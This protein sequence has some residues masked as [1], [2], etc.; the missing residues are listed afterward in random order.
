MQARLK[1]FLIH[2]GIS[3]LIAVGVVALVFGLWYPS[4]LAYRCW[5]NTNIF[6][7]VG[8]RRLPWPVINFRGL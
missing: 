7:V 4:P 2:F 1:A 5:R 3:I 8:S 6:I